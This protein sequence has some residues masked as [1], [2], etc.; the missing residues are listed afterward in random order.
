MAIT[1]K[2]K[3]QTVDTKAA[4]VNSGLQNFF[5][6]FSVICNHNIKYKHYNFQHLN[7]NYLNYLH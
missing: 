3:S 1:A 7:N 4:S 5:K 2:P 6:Q